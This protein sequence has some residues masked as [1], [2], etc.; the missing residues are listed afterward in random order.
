MCNFGR[1]QACTACCYCEW[2]VV[3][4]VSK[5]YPHATSSPHTHIKHIRNVKKQAA[6]FPPVSTQT[7]FGFSPNLSL[8]SASVR[9]NG[10]PVVHCTNGAVYTYDSALAA[11]VKLSET[12]WAEGSDVWQGRQR[13]NAPTANRGIMTAIEGSLA[14]AVDESASAQKPRPAWW[15]AALTLGH[16][17]TRMHATRLL[18][19]PQEHRQALLVYAK[20]IADEGFRGKAEELVRELFGP[21]YWCVFAGGLCA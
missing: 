21:V 14:G 15:G 17:E 3:L 5:R 2:A 6:N 20:K 8:I 18:A 7:I 1:K 12:W 4:L 11:W 10:A 9:E 13:G 19:S 16:L